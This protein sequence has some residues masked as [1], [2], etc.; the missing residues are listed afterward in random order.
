MA[1]TPTISGSPSLISADINSV[2]TGSSQANIGRYIESHTITENDIRICSAVF[3]SHLP[4]L[5]FYAKFSGSIHVF[6]TLSFTR[7]AALRGHKRPVF[8]MTTCAD[9]SGVP[10]LL[11]SSYDNTLRLWNIKEM[12]CDVVISHIIGNIYDLLIANVTTN[13]TSYAPTGEEMKAHPLA[14]SRPPAPPLCSPSTHPYYS[15]SPLPATPYLSLSPA[16]SSPSL[17]LLLSSLA[18]GRSA[19]DDSPKKDPILFFGCQDTCVKALN[20]RVLMNLVR[21]DTVLK[22]ERDTEGQSGGNVSVGT[23]FHSPKEVTMTNLQVLSLSLCLSLTHSLS[24]PLTVTNSSHLT[25]VV[26]VHWSHRHREG[27]RGVCVLSCPIRKSP[28]QRRR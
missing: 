5:L 25:I 4:H 19:Y 6:D 27:S 20:L 3:A 24:L 17:V 1:V 18:D 22:G 26:T 12:R 28:F 8:A 14:C 11:S 7:V 15:P 13:F 21:G 2:P 10:L 16:S 9:V 23:P